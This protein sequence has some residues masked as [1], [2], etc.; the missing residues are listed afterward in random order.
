M[1]NQIYDAEQNSITRSRRDIGLP[2]LILGPL[3]LENVIQS[4]L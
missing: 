2:T 3:N 1:N 4:M